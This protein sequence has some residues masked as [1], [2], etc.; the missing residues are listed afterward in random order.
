MNLAICQLQCVTH[1][2]DQDLDNARPVRLLDRDGHLKLATTELVRLMRFMLNIMH[3]MSSYGCSSAIAC[4]LSLPAR[5][6]S[7]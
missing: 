7:G 2:R 3:L 5:L 1:L 4:A 6:Q